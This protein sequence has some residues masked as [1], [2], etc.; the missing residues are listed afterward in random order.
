MIRTTNKFLQNA[1][2]CVCFVST[3]FLHYRR[4]VITGTSYASFPIVRAGR[5]L[6]L[7]GLGDL[8]SDV[9]LLGVNNN[10]M[11]GLLPVIF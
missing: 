3:F 10:F 6:F 8:G 7:L 5:F 4:C 2:F 1:L 9:L 11:L